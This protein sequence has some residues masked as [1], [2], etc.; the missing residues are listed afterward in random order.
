MAQRV[1]EMVSEEIIDEST[2]K[3]EVE[4]AKKE[5]KEDVEEA[6]EEV[7]NMFSDEL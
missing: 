7:R 5:F 1:K 2:V 3:K 4:E 6:K